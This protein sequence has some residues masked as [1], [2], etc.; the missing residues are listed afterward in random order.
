MQLTEPSRLACPAC[1][2]AAC[3]QLPA[4]L[5]VMVWW[6]YLQWL[7]L[8]GAPCLHPGGGPAGP[9]SRSPVPPQAPP[10]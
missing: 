3:K 10:L 2:V 9:V 6:S 4:A 1:T 7:S 5:L 8:T